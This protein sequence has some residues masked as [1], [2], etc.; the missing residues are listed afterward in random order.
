MAVAIPLWIVAIV[1]AEVQDWGDGVL[2]GVLLG[3]A[4][5]TTAVG[6]LI[7]PKPLP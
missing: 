2:G 5:V 3:I 4:G 7:A 1:L 6:T